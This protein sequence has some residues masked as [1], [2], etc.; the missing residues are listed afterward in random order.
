[1]V[2]KGVGIKNDQFSLP[3]GNLPKEISVVC[4]LKIIESIMV[5]PSGFTTAKTSPPVDN[6]KFVC[7]SPCSSSLSH[8]ISKYS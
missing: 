6:L 1:L 7:R 5:C 4:W 2:D 3:S 8:Q